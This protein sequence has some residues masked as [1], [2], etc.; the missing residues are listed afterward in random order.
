MTEFINPKTKKSIQDVVFAYKQKRDQTLADLAFTEED[1]KNQMSGIRKKVFADFENNLAVAQKNLENNGFKVYS[2]ADKSGAQEILKQLISDNE[3][4]VKSK[5]NTA[6][7]IEIEKVVET[8]ETDLGDYLVEFFQEDDM[9][10]VLPAL[11]LTPE[12]IAKK[13]KEKFSDEVEPTAQKLTHYLSDRIRQRI[14][15]A[16]VGVT[17]ANFLTQTGQIVLLENEGNISLISR[18]AKKH[19][20]IVGIDKLVAT[21]EDA[22]RLCQAAAVFGTGQKITQYISVISGPAKTADI[23][24]EMVMGAQG[25]KEVHVILVDNGRRRLLKEGFGEMLRC[26]NCGAC[27]NFCPVYHNLGKHYGG[28]YLGSKGVVLEAFLNVM[29]DA[30]LNLEASMQKGSFQCTLC[31]GCSENCPM[32]IDLPDL[33]RRLRQWQNEQGWQTTPNKEMKQKINDYGNP[34]GQ[35]ED[36]KL[37]DKLYCC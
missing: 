31:G 27:I 26:L 9:H 32:K 21:V 12:R 33:M 25:A 24:N 11:H 36:K 15:K 18:L 23:Q 22:T 34:F 14:L 10:Y 37:P 13:I 1:F 7:E 35:V 17:G 28:T 5:S 16:D 4:V 8:H 29:N 20:V 3:Y 6:K 30:K 2:A 19:V